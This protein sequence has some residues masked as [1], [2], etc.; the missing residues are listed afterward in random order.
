MWGFLV[1]SPC[2]FLK[3]PLFP[4]LQRNRIG[5]W[6]RA[7]LLGTLTPA[8]RWSEPSQSFPQAAAQGALTW[9]AQSRHLCSPS[10]E[11]G[12]WMECWW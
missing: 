4:G 6:W 10:R 11:L 7:F 1:D 5:I 2:G 12:Q 8:G 3:H 9:E